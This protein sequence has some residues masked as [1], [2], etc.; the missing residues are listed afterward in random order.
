MQS[1]T[2]I[3]TL[4]YLSN[5]IFYEVFGYLDN[6][7]SYSAFS[8]LNARFQNLLAGRSLRL[9]IQMSRLPGRDQP[10]PI[11]HTGFNASKK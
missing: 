10:L 1:T 2:S 4:E 7:D 5:E 9:K 3:T 8:S 6:A 11:R